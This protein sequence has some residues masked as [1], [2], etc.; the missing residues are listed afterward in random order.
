MSETFQSSDLY[1]EEDNGEFF[2]CCNDQVLTTDRGHNISYGRIGLIDQMIAE[3][4]HCGTITIENRV[5]IEPRTV[6]SY[7][8]YSMQKDWVE[9]GKDDLT[10]DF[11]N[12]IVRDGCLFRCAGPEGGA[13]LGKWAPILEYLAAL[14][15]TLPD[16]IGPFFDDPSVYDSVA[17]Y[18]EAKAA[19]HPTSDFTNRLKLAYQRLTNSQKAVVMTLHSHHEGVVLFPMVLVLGKCTP[20]EYASGVIAALASIHGV[21]HDVSIAKHRNMFS[22]IREHARSATVFLNSCNDWLLDQARELIQD[23]NRSSSH[24]A[25]QSVVAISE[26]PASP[27]GKQRTAEP[28]LTTEHW[29]DISFVID[30]K[31]EVLVYFGRLTIGQQITKRQGVRISLPG[32]QWRSLLNCLAASQD[33]QQAPAGELMQHIGYLPQFIDTSNRVSVR[34]AIQANEL[35]VVNDPSRRLDVAIRDLNKKLRIQIHGPSGRGRAALRYDKQEGIVRA[36]FVTRCVMTDGNGHLF[37]GR[38]PT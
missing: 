5:V 2:L 4:N 10:L 25:R 34:A 28:Q 7:A 16:L 32:Q 24:V 11:A 6:S 26:T 35:S 15:L 1:V 20:D 23:A 30:E 9:S 19:S 21:F 8:F 31:N 29:S 38:I 13:Q 3:L 36:E 22:E 27:F 33:G 18:E 37:F 14:K 17:D 12:S